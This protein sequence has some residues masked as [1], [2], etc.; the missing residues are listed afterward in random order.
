MMLRFSFD[1]DKE[2]D[3]IEAAIKKVLQENYRTCDIMDDGMTLV[4]CS[5]MGD[6]ICQRL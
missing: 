6:L 2:A 5:E 3:S 1:M 4:S